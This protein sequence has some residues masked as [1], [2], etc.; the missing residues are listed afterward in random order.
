MLRAQ[1]QGPATQGPPVS[2]LQSHSASHPRQDF[3]GHPICLGWCPDLMEMMTQCD[4]K[5]QEQ[6]APWVRKAGTPLSS[7][8]L[9]VAAGL[10][11]GAPALRLSGI[12]WGPGLAAVGRGQQPGGAQGWGTR[13][14]GALPAHHHFSPHSE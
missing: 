2:P 1:G 9:P 5:A 3:P 6:A 13:T 14:G 4:S 10:S 12:I 7:G 8:G 11:C